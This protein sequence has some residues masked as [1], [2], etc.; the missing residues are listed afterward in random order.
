MLF[1][2]TFLLINQILGSIKDTKQIS[3]PS[4]KNLKQ[5]GKGDEG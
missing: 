3:L 2:L 4:V 1:Q 5:E